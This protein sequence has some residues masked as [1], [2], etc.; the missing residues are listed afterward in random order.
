M[1]QPGVW[2]LAFMIAGLHSTANSSEVRSASDGSSPQQGDANGQ[3]LEGKL[4][5]QAQAQLETSLLNKKVV[6]KIVFPA[7]HLGIEVSID[8]QWDM[9]KATRCIKDCGMGIDVG[10]AAVI[11]TV[12]LKSEHIEIHLNG[13]GAGT[14]GDVMLGVDRSSQSGKVPGGSRINLHFNRPI[15]FEDIQDLNRLASYL[16]P[17]VDPSAINQAATLAAIPEAFKRAAEDGQ[18][19]QGMDK[20]T[21]F[22]IMGEPKNKNVDM[23]GDVPIEKW[24]F[25]LANLKTRVVTFMQGIVVKVMEF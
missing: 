5:D 21:V 18:V 9:K 1:R 17:V 14:F 12:K 23:S 2:L 6:S 10:D 11:T 24:Q 19:V 3:R 20:A 13:G 7:S 22:A 25:D 16:E 4:K 15:T 8:G